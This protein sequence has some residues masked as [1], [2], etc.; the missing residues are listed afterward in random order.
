MAEMTSSPT[1]DLPTINPGT[2]LSL[3][4]LEYIPSVDGY[5][6]AQAGSVWIYK[7]ADWTH[8]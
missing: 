7:P 8:P 2:G 1:A 6:L 3:S 5:I 4:R